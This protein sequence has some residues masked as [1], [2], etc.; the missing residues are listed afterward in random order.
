MNLTQRLCWKLFGC[1][2]VLIARLKRIYPRRVEYLP[3][4]GMP[5]IMDLG[6]LVVL[7]PGGSVGPG[8]AVSQWSNATPESIFDGVKMYV[9]INEDRLLK[10]QDNI[11]KYGSLMMEDAADLTIWLIPRVRE[12]IDHR[13]TADRLQG[14]KAKNERILRDSPSWLTSGLGTKED[15]EMLE[16]AQMLIDDDIEI[17]DVPDGYGTGN[18]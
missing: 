16:L 15:Q 4:T 5:Y 3:A 6:C 10:M 13:L 12:R 18:H 2:Y 11:E 17:E 14:M 1:K 8:T 9:E 7:H